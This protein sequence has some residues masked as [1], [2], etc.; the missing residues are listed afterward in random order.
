MLLFS[1]TPDINAAYIP[2]GDDPIDPPPGDN[3][4]DPIRYGYIIVGYAKDSATGLP[5]SSATVKYYRSGTYIGQSKTST[6]GLFRYGY[7]SM[8]PVSSFTV[9]ISKSGYSTI[10]RTQ[11]TSD[12]E[13]NFGTIYLVPLKI[14]TIYGNVKEMY[15]GIDIPSATVLIYTGTTYLG[16]ATTYADSEYFI[17][18]YSTTSTY[19][20]FTAKASKPGYADAEKTLTGS[21]TSFNIGD[22]EL[23][24][25]RALI[26]SNEFSY[27][28][29]AYPQ[30]WTFSSEG[31]HETYC[32]DGYAVVHETTGDYS[33]Y[34]YVK[35]HFDLCMWTHLSSIELEIRFRISSDY[36]GPSS[37]STAVFGF[38]TY[39]GHPEDISSRLW[40][41]PISWQW[42]S[43]TW[44][45]TR[46]YTITT[47]Q[48]PSATSFDFFWGYE[49]ES[50]VNLNQRVYLDYV[51]AYGDSYPG[52]LVKSVNDIYHTEPTPIAFEF[53]SED[54][55]DVAVSYC[56]QITADNTQGFLQNDNS[57]HILSAICIVLD[58]DQ[59]DDTNYELNY[60]LVDRV[61][62]RIRV[63]NQWNVPSGGTHDVT[64][65]EV[66][67]PLGQD[68]SSSLFISG[69]LN[70][71]AEP[72]GWTF[73]GP[74]R[75]VI[76]LGANAIAFAY[77]ALSSE[78]EHGG[79]SLEHHYENGTVEAT[80]DFCSVP[81]FQPIHGTEDFKMEL[82]SELTSL[83]N[84]GIYYVD[85]EYEVVLKEVMGKATDGIWFYMEGESETF[86]YQDHITLIKYDDAEDFADIHV[87]HFASDED[88]SHI[89]CAAGPGT[90]VIDTH[91]PGNWKVVD[92]S[93]ITVTADS[94]YSR[95]VGD[96]E[97]HYLF[98]ELYI[99]FWKEG[100]LRLI[101]ICT[102]SN[103]LV[104]TLDQHVCYC[105]FQAEYEL[106]RI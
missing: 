25:Y 14:Y 54:V 73:F 81:S 37:R 64:G 94:M 38:T 42:C 87:V 18:S 23:D 47:E 77:G 21:G 86:Y 31:N 65:I 3:P 28:P 13:C 56:T 50:T 74:Y 32:Q 2:P 101:P 102:T 29:E 27:N 97:S 84:N 79:D 26:A 45:I 70:L 72:L 105:L 100:R 40:Y 11:A 36:N 88:G 75:P 98:T 59:D 106:S 92:G 55:D 7:S 46:T 51:R 20:S 5:I 83:T 63:T 104:Y 69:L 6:A 41:E 43:D 44:W 9:Q 30:Y 95:D 19:T 99:S 34:A 78:Y 24:T 93:A 76:K 4:I 57:P 71:A 62:V 39:D 1:V 15:S 8:F 58:P 85:V 103:T 22:I 67:Q 89:S 33:P 60:N 82:K 96:Y 16:Q 17:F 68:E 10:T 61:T 91:Y 49:D 48:L 90:A 66:N 12:I 53:G 35:G 80:F 52:P